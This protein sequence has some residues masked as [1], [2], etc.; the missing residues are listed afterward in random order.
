MGIQFY[1]GLLRYRDKDYQG[2]ISAFNRAVALRGDYSNARYFL[3]L[4]YEKVGRIDNAIEQFEVVER[5]NPDNQEVKHILKNLRGGNA[6]F[7][8]QGGESPEERG[9]PPIREGDDGEDLQQTE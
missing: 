1:L 9:T 7:E 5:Y 2:A 4:S 8:G 6:P 3:G